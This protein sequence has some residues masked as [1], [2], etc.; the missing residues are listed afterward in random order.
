MVVSKDA[1]IMKRGQKVWLVTWEGTETEGV[2]RD[3]IVTIL[4]PRLSQRRV[5]EIIE[6]LYAIHTY[7]PSEIAGWSRQPKELPYRA[8][9]DGSICLC[10]HNPYLQA[11]FVHNF[12]IEEDPDTGLETIKWIYPP[13]Y[14][15][16]AETSKIEQ[17]R[18][19]MPDSTTRTIRG[20]L[21][22]GD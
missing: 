3:R 9:W 22:A 15:L 14:R 16:N 17:V 12:L 20:P 4:R 8:V 21:R 10:G 6:C 5:G 1:Y 7:T 13:R 19:D 2:G 11:A 18:G